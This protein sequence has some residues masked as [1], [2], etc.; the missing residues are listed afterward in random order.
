MCQEGFVLC[1][2]SF[3]LYK[4]CDLGRWIWFWRY[5]CFCSLSFPA[6]RRSP[7]CPIS[8]FGSLH[9]LY[10]GNSCHIYVY[11]RRSF[12]YFLLYH[13]KPFDSK[14]PHL[15]APAATAKRFFMPAQSVILQKY[16][17]WNSSSHG[18]IDGFVLVLFASRAAGFLS[19]LLLCKLHSVLCICE[20]FNSPSRA[21][22][23]KSWERHLWVFHTISVS[24]V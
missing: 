4:N 9:Q 5:P 21:C 6:L 16:H 24:L 13:N 19:L 1:G 15:F 20:R 11:L 7:I 18:E 2:E 10:V 3:F 14:L 12:A 23:M 17:I 22:P 8:C